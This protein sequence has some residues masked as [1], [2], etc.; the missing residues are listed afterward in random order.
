MGAGG[1]VCIY[2]STRA[3][4]IA[5]VTGFF[6]PRA[7]YRPLT[8]VRLLDTRPAASTIDGRDAG[9]GV[10]AAGSVL[11]LDV[12]GRGGTAVDASAVSLNLTVTETG[13]AGFA[14]VFPCGERRPDASTIN[15]GPGVTIA[16]AIV[17]KVGAGGKVCVYTHASAQL[18]VDVNGYFPA[19]SEFRSLTPARLLDTRPTV[20][21]LPAPPSDAAAVSLALLNELRTAHGVGPLVADASMS[22]AALAWSQ[23][24]AR[25]GFRHSSTGDAENIAWHSSSSLSPAQ[26]ATTF[27]QMWV[28]SPGHLREHARSAVDASRDRPVRR[29]IRVVRHAHVPL[30]R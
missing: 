17:S 19:G 3:D 20:S 11:E 14:T 30:M 12:T 10:R 29:R 27:Q 22:A 23:E 5:D 13:G 8:P 1:K 26:A 7:A 28:D 18:I 16:N 9:G 15:F 2:S 25:S 24:M 4:V 6:G 21:A